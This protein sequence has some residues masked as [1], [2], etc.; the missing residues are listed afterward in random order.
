MLVCC[1]YDVVVAVVVGYKQN[2]QLLANRQAKGARLRL[3]ARET[4]ELPE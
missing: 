1:F 2:E 4:I 3:R